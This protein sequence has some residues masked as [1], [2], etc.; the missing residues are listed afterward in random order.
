MTRKTAP[1]SVTQPTA[2]DKLIRKQQ[3]ELRRATTKRDELRQQMNATDKLAGQLKWSL[4][5]TESNTEELLETVLRLTR[6]DRLMLELD[7]ERE[8]VDTLERLLSLQQ[9]VFGEPVEGGDERRAGDNHVTQATEAKLAVHVRL[10]RD[11][12]DDRSVG[13]DGPSM[14]VRTQEAIDAFADPKFDWLRRGA[15]EG[16]WGYIKSAAA[17]AAK[18]KTE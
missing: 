17:A 15:E 10:L 6:E 1:R 7:L 14:P 11:L 13:W 16:K 4:A 5:V 9:W 18:T 3:L 12:E 8:I 2:T